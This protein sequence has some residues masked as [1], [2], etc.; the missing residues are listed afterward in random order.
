MKIVFAG[1]DPRS[2]VVLKALT[3][4]G[5][6]VAAVVTQP[7]RP[8]GRK[9]VLTPNPVKTAAEKEGIPVYD[10][11]KIREHAAFLAGLGADCMITC[12]YGQILSADVLDAFPGGVYNVHT[13]LLPRWRGASPVQHAI[14]AGDEE[15]GVTIMRTET[16]LDTGDILLTKKTRILPSHTAGTLADELFVLGAEAVLEALAMLEGGTA[17]FTPQD[18]SRAS[19]CGKITKQDARIDFS[20]P[21]DRISAAVRAYNPQPLAYAFLRGKAVNF[22]FAESLPEDGGEGRPG[23]ILRADRTG[24]YVR[25]GQGTV[26]ILSLQEEGGKVLSASDFANGRKAAPGDM[27][28]GERL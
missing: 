5:K 18:S 3:D 13:S 23:E 22:F 8:A 4:A 2:P 25:A 1:A 11:P 27:F 28:A 19:M 17:V 15:T 7:D 24:I 20:Q 6:D 16:G 10:F 21:A 26:R 9:R 12:A 14:L